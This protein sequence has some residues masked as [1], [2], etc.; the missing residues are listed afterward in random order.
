MER[1]VIY[2]QTAQRV[3]LRGVLIIYPDL[4]YA[5]ANPGT[6]SLYLLHERLLYTI[7]VVLEKNFLA[8]IF[9]KKV[10]RIVS[11]KNAEMDAQLAKKCVLVVQLLK[12]N[13]IRSL[14]YLDER[15]ADVD[16]SEIISALKAIETIPT[17]FSKMEHLLYA[18]R[19]IP[20]CVSRHYANKV[21]GASIGADD[22]LPIFVF[23][24]LHSLPM[25]L[26]SSK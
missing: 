13:A 11:E 26:S 22:F 1:L 20:L 4:F 23:C 3:L 2:I 19:L 18:T 10:E 24:L 6:K 8:R 16:F 25:Y 12:P 21:E 14:L 9:A 7:A 5:T 17:P 15:F